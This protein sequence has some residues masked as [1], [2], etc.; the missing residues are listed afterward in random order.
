MTKSFLKNYELIQTEDGSFTLF[1]KVFTENCHSTH[2]AANETNLHYLEGCEIKNRLQKYQVMNVLEVGF[3][4]GLGWRLT[5]DLFFTCPDNHFHFVTLEK[6]PDL[7]DWYQTQFPEDEWVKNLPTGEVRTYSFK[8]MTLT[9]LIGDARETLPKYLSLSPLKFHA[10]YQDAFSPRKNPDLWTVE[11]F[12]LLKKYSDEE[13]ILSTY[14]ASQSIQKSLVKAGYSIYK[15]HAFGPKRASTRACLN[16]KSDED[17][18]DKL[19]RSPIE[20]LFDK[21]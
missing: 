19:S 14:S 17:L 20:P 21:K 3:G 7:I 6:D 10:I 12:S 18:M 11:W 2:G 13:V 4:T 8:N 5:R 1:S 9:I 16:R 15:G